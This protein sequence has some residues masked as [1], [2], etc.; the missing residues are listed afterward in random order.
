MFCEWLGKKS[1]GKNLGFLNYLRMGKGTTTMKITT[2][3][4]RRIIK[5]EIAKVVR[6]ADE[7]GS[8]GGGGSEEKMQ[9]LLAKY[10]TEESEEERNEFEY[11]MDELADKVLQDNI[12]D[13]DSLSPDEKMGRWREVA[14]LLDEEKYKTFHDAVWAGWSA[15]SVKESRKRK[16][17]IRRR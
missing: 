17:P 1:Q 15:R 3:Q 11:Q 5:E 12:F 7:G 10:L 13:I 16:Q 14:D 6:E 9:K 2:T 8:S 4:L